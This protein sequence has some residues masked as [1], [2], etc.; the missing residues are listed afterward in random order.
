MGNY[1]LGRLLRAVPV[2]LIAGFIVFLLL[3]LVP[4][5]PA[6]MRAGVDATPED[7]AALRTDLGLDRSLPEQYARWVMLALQGDFGQSFV[8]R[9]PVLA[10]VGDRFPATLQLAV[11]AILMTALVGVPLGIVAAVRARSGTDWAI[12]TGTAF[13]IGVPDFWLGTV[14]ILVFAVWLGLLPPGGYESVIEDP[15]AGL[16]YLV[17]PVVALA[18]RPAAV[19]SRFTRAAILDVAREEYVW[20]ARSKGVREFKV[21]ML[22]ILP[23]ALIPIMTILA[24]QFGYMFSATVVVEAVFGWPGLGGLL[25]SAIRE[26]DYAVVQAVMLL[27]VVLFIVINLVADL[28]YARLDPRIALGSRP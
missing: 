21:V 3:H 13:A 27:L 20:T 16:R 12:T 22:H 5:D 11:F 17:L 25:V 2:L 15:V 7:I 24:I 18:A 28:L 14:G 6:T 4:G 10:L 23:N 8:S 1:I 19:I 9:R 26:R